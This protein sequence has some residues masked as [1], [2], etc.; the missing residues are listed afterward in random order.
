MPAACVANTGGTIGGSEDINGIEV[1]SEVGYDLSNR[2]KNFRSIACHAED[3]SST[4]IIISA[5]SGPTNR[6]SETFWARAT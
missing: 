1:G 3:R 4:D 6:I 5:A 2:S